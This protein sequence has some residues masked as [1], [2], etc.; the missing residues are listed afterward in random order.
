MGQRRPEQTEQVTNQHKEWP[1]PGTTR[2]LTDGTRHPQALYPS[3]SHEV[4]FT[5]LRMGCHL[6]VRV[7]PIGTTRERCVKPP[8]SYLHWG[9]HL[10]LSGP[11]ERHLAM[12]TLTR[13]Q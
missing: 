1:A 4:Y 9:V 12:L 6:T 3:L 8:D 10:P 7:L 11:M 13:L 2:D 5:P